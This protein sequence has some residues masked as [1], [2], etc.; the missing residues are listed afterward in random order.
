MR[1]QKF[2]FRLLFIMMIVCTTN[3][4]GQIIVSGDGPDKPVKMDYSNPKE[5]E[6]GGITSS[7]TAPLDQR[8]LSFH[9]GDKIMIP[10]DEI[11]NSIKAL[12]RTGLYE[13]VEITLSR[14]SGNTAFIDVRL[15]D[16]S[17]LI[18]F[19]FKGTTKADETDLR[20]KLHISQG[21][22][23]NDNLRPPVQTSSRSTMWKKVFTTAR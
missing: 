17:R 3:S 14:V 6:I 8:L 18:S 15:E 16:R 19:G 4:Y 13:D 12:W 7:G 22:I 2:I 21:N 10:G 1:L 20:D 23:V 9:V 11:S 5:Y